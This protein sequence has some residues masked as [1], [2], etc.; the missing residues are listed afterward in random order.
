MSKMR[1]PRFRRL[2][3]PSIA[4]LLALSVLIGLGYWQ[5]QRRAW[6]LDLIE[7]I[8]SRV[9]GESVSL[10]LVKEAWER[11]RDV[12]YYRVLLVGHFEH[13]QERHL[14]TVV[15]GQAGW[16]VITP[17]ITRQGEIVLTDRGFVPE[18]LKQPE[19]R[20]Q[21]QIEGQIEMI[22]LARAP[23]ERHW[24]APEHDLAANRWFWRDI[25]G[26]AASLPLEER[27]KVLPFMVEAEDEDIPGGWPRGG[28]TILDLPNRHLE[29]ALTWFGLAITLVIIFLIFA[30]ARLRET[31][32]EPDNGIIAEQ[33]SKV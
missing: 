17:F 9:Y 16:R 24:F 31:S 32:P 10:S 11:E 3:V 21:G 8:D 33:S 30:R 4:A 28:V 13:S 14:Y 23:V 25:P 7:R 5:L 29:Y 18:A 20:S 19:A 1:D 22:G 2:I 15:D 26:M 6:K 27:T 12:E